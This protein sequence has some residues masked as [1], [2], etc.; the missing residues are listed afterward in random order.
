[1]SREYARSQEHV[2]SNAIRSLDFQTIYKEYRDANAWGARITSFYKMMK[3]TDL[4]AKLVCAEAGVE[5]AALA[6][7]DRQKDRLTTDAIESAMGAKELVNVVAPQSSLRIA[8]VRL[9]PNMP[10]LIT[11]KVYEEK[12]TVT[13]LRNGFETHLEEMTS[14]HTEV[15]PTLPKKDPSRWEFEGQLAESY[16]LLSLQRYVLR[17][18][19]T[20][21]IPLPAIGHENS[22]SAR[23]SWTQPTWDISVL[24]CSGESAPIEPLHKLQ[25]KRQ[26]NRNS[27]EQRYDDDITMIYVKNH[28]ALPNEGSRHSE[29]GHVSMGRLLHETLPDAHPDAVTRWNKRTIN[30]V[31]MLQ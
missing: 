25:V 3:F 31:G 9:L 21:W 23:G 27:F 13:Q 11:Q 16:I 20:K 14:I 15:L 26:F 17:N 4:H 28:M 19:S 12:P 2:R 30:L 10:M 8:A 5:L 24:D 1:M 18:K 22:T 6:I 7:D 29:Y